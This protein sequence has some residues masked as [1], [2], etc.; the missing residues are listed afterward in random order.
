MTLAALLSLLVVLLGLSYI[1][2]GLR[3]K[4]GI[5]YRSA[6][7]VLIASVFV[8][9][10]IIRIPLS[11][12]EYQSAYQKASFGWLS[13]AAILQSMQ[14]A[15]RTFVLDG[16]WEELLPSDKGG[17]KISLFATVVGLSLNVIAPVLTFSAIMSFFKDITSKIRI[18]AMSVSKRPLFLFSELNKDTVFLAEDISKKYPNAN[19]V[20]TDVY[21]EDDE[22]NYELRE[23]VGK[24]HAVMLRTDISELSIKRNEHLTEYFLFGH[25]EEENVMQA[26]KLFKKHLSCKNTG[27]YVLSVNKGNELILDSLTSSN[28]VEE[29]FDKLSAEG[30]SYQ[31]MKDYIRNGGILKLRR[32]DPEKQIAWREIPEIQSIKD[33]F[34]KEPV[35]APKALS[36]LLIADTHLSYS[37]IKTLIWYCQSDKFNLELN[38]VYSDLTRS[39]VDTAYGSSSTIINVKNLVEYE[40]PDIIRTN[41]IKIDGDAFYDI[42]FIDKSEF[43]SGLFQQH[44]INAAG[45]DVE[46]PPQVKRLLKTSVAIVDRGIDGATL[47]T[48]ASLRT[49]FERLNM[50]PEIYAVCSDEEETLRDISSYNNIVTYKDENYNIRFIGKRSDTYTYD[51]IKNTEEENLG[52][53]QHIKWIDVQYTDKD[54]GDRD[55]LLKN[56]LLNYERHEYFRNSSISK[57]KYMRKVLAD[58][59]NE[60]SEE[61]T[62]LTI[63]QSSAAK[64]VFDDNT[65]F[66][67]RLRIRPEYEC[68]NEPGI[69]RGRWNCTCEKCMTRRKLEHIRWNAYMRTEG[70]IPSPLNDLKDKRPLA[71]VHGN[72]VPFEK[73]GKP[74]REKDG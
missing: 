63:N 58:P 47:E 43:E 33:A 42:E 36:I 68:I 45:K 51:S 9:L 34:S 39:Q 74:D 11:F 73:L 31:I 49:L 22:T 30:M 55:S 71:K 26:R 57:A 7:A 2:W 23:R 44:L 65:F 24:L 10:V 50:K 6:V 3:V 46:I 64:G 59:D 48:S 5:G 25:D 70:Y 4:N 56:E 40:C 67:W 27:I 32:I 60:L 19:L 38:I 35:S 69:P 52:F 72:I 61:E 28:N 16:S 12:Y 15:F 8:G 18:R 13:F 66:E 53:C 29:K 20:Y 21:P 37:I 62:L 1:V 41:K 14:N 17:I 54:S